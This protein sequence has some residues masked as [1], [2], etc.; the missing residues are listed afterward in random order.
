MIAGNLKQ[1]LHKHGQVICHDCGVNTGIYQPVVY[2]RVGDLNI[3][4]EFILHTGKIGWL[5]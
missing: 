5:I 4:D 2:H 3:V 1:T